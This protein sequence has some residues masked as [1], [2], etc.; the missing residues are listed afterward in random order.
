MH[1]SPYFAKIILN[2]AFAV[3]LY[4]ALLLKQ[5][6]PRKGTETHLFLFLFHSVLEASY[7]PQGDG[8]PPIHVVLGIS[9]EA[10]Y[11]PQGDGNFTWAISSRAPAREASYTPQGDG[12]QRRDVDTGVGI[13]ETTYTPQ[14][15]EN[16]VFFSA[17]T[18]SAET[19]YTPQGDENQSMGLLRMSTSRNNL[20]P[21][22]GRKPVQTLFQ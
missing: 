16:L 12:N 22:R 7:T 14:G 1:V 13:T 10:S 15:D 9:R 8:N 21:A 19:T 11:T 4:W 5:A 20:H 17:L 3:L 18:R 6:T 2:A